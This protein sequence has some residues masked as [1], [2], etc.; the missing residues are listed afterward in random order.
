MASKGFKF[1]KE[2][3][4]GATCLVFLCYYQLFP[5]FIFNSKEENIKI[6]SIFFTFQH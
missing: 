1:I 6:S 4:K 5:G 2:I 3:Y